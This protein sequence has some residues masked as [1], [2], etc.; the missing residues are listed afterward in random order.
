[1]GVKDKHSVKKLMGKTLEPCWVA[2]DQSQGENRSRAGV[3]WSSFQVFL[4]TLACKPAAHVPSS[5][6]LHLPLLVINTLFLV[7][8]VKK[9]LIVTEGTL[10]QGVWEG[11]F[12]WI[13]DFHE[14]LRSS[15]EVNIQ[16]WSMW[17]TEHL[18]PF[19]G[20]AFY[21]LRSSGMFLVLNSKRLE[22]FPSGLGLC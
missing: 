7:G 2:W 3:R 10:H 8:I 17:A 1:M 6:W 12:H 11:W 16:G 18:I 5:W 21:S 9:H 4:N 22:W 14:I 19:G 20:Q 15:T 13:R